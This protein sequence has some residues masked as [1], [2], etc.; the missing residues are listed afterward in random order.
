LARVVAAAPHGE[1]PTAAHELLA[2]RQA[3]WRR[4]F[5]A[6]GWRVR[7]AG[8][9]SLFYTGYGLAPS[10]PLDLRRRLAAVLGAGC[11]WFIVE[12]DA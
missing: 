11:N 8:E 7:A 6:G 5:E 2:F 1:F 12:R 3:A 9:S 10:M 4:R